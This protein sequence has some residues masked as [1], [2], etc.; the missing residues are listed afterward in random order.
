MTGAIKQQADSSQNV[1][2]LSE[3]LSSIA[4]NLVEQINKFKM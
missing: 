2:S 3:E 4:E 1:S